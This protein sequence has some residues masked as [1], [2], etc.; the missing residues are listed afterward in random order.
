MVELKETIQDLIQR[1]KSLLAFN[2]QNIWQLEALYETSKLL[3]LPV[4]A[5]FSSKYINYFHDHFDFKRLISKYQN[6]K[7]FFHLDHSNNSSIIRFCIDCG[8][9]SVMYDGSHEPVSVNI[10]NSNKFYKYA[11]NKALLEV[12]IG[13]IGGIEDGFGT[14]K[15]NYFDD[16]DLVLFA[17]TAKFDLLAL[18]IGNLHG[19][20]NSVAGVKIDLL[21]HSNQLIGKF[22]LVLHGGTGLP[23]DMIFKAIEYGVVKINIST[24]LKVETAKLLSIF[25]STERYYDEIKLST[26]IK[27]G[28]TEYFIPLISKFTKK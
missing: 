3:S 9:A 5:Q 13:S 21:Q 8:F 19:E 17:E 23:D 14:E 2:I 24:S 11:D 27:N 6:N 7:F 25:C 20:Y 4:M 1:K 15:L 16:S 12:E 10:D 28:L 22:P 18:G 26:G